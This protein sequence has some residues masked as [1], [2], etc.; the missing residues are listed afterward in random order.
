MSSSS[1]ARATCSPCRVPG[2]RPAAPRNC[3]AL[4]DIPALICAA[5]SVGRCLF[6]NARQAR[7]AGAQPAELVGQDIARVLGPERAARGRPRDREVLD[8]GR[9]VPPYWDGGPRL[10]TAKAPLRAPDG[11]VIGVVTTSVELHGPPGD[12]AP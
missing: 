6:V 2:A 12:G 10:L 9:D 3:P 5:D 1:R 7:A 4:D 8:T 11:A